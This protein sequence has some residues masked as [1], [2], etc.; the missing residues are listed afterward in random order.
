MNEV[1]FFENE[2][3]SSPLYYIDSYGGNNVYIKR[4]DLIPFSFGGNKVRKARN[5]YKEI[6]DRKCDSV[7]TYGSASSNHCRIIANMCKAMGI[8]CFVVSPV[9]KYEST[10]NSKM[11]SE[12]GATIIQAPLNEIGVTIDNKLEELRRSGHNPYQILGGGHGNMGTMAYV[13]TYKEIKEFEETNNI[14]FDYIFHAS[15]T[16]T[17]QAGLVCGQLM[18]CDE[19][20][21]IGLSIAREQV[22]GRD[23]VKESIIDY[24]SFAGL[25]I[26]ETEVEDKL[27]FY[28]DYRLGGYGEYNDEITFV[29]AEVLE[30]YGIPMDT[31]YV[32]KAFWGMKQ[33]IEKEKLMGK[34]ILFIHT[35]G[36]PLFFNK[37]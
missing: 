11:I 25:D 1:A 7:V 15:G 21:I 24:I 5:F 6:R 27:H 32:G 20:S 31:T 12:F 14:R 17:T 36:T 22:R 13:D 16:G 35:G 10:P 30:K 9:E 4:D 8:Q 23:V 29:I 33:Y 34:N 18:N 3:Q 19:R 37:M 28:D 26:T 2:M